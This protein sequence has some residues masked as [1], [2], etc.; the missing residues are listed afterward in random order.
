MLQLLLEL[1]IYKI[2]S[3]NNKFKFIFSEE[4]GDKMV[5]CL[6]CGVCA[7]ILAPI[8]FVVIFAVFGLISFL[9]IY[10]TIISKKKTF[11]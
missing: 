9:I 2:Q 6:F 5:N 3:N 11:Y 8:I 7:Y 10:Y 1:E 4:N